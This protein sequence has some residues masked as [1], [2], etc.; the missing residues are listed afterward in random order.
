MATRR[1]CNSVENMKNAI[2][3]TYEHYSSTDKHPQHS[4]CPSGT[5]S[6]CAWQRASASGT[7]VSFTHDYTPLPEDVLTTIKPIYEDLSKTELLEKCVSG[8]THN[9]NEI[10]ISSL[11]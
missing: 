11:F 10:I 1:N 6:W 2:W 7:L 5:E 8:F 4:K 3:A 9:N